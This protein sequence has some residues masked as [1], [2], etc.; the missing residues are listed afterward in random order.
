MAQCVCGGGTRGTDQ[1][2]GGDQGTC[3]IGCQQTHVPPCALDAAGVGSCDMCGDVKWMSRMSAAASGTSGLPAG[4]PPS[5]SVMGAGVVWGATLA[6]SGPSCFE[7][8][9]AGRRVGLGERRG[10]AGVVRS[11]AGAGKSVL[12]RAPHAGGADAPCT[13]PRWL[14]G[15]LEPTV[16]E[17][18]SF[19][20]AGRVRAGLGR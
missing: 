14:R 13:V 7:A 3:G 6:S 10:V 20:A 5:A 19:G 12:G 11:H 1:Q 9:H 18:G 8:T 2:R 4:D 15:R 17:G 16:I